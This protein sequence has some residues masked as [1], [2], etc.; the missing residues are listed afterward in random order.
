M[1]FIPKNTRFFKLSNAKIKN[2][3][4]RYSILQVKD[5]TYEPSRG[6]PGLMSYVAEGVLLLR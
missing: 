3:N 4:D 6:M 5:T 2:E 1:L